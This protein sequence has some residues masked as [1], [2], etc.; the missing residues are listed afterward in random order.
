MSLMDLIHRR[1]NIVRQESDGINLAVYFINQFQGRT[2]TFRGLK[3]KHFG[4]KDK[5]VLR[6]I[7][8]E[9]DSM[10]ILYRYAT[11]VKTYTDKRG[12]SQLKHSNKT[13]E[14]VASRLENSR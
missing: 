7:E 14:F 12:V 8:E 4:V 1:T 3:S 9:L 2:F 6:L 11:M 13:P 10:L 5:E